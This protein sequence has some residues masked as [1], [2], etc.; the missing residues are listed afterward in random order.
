MP[1]INVKTFY[2]RA[3]LVYDLHGNF[4]EEID[5]KTKAKKKYSNGVDKVLK[6]VQQQ[7]RGFIFKYK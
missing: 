1:E 6:G 5:T 4:I 7:C 3:I 2:K